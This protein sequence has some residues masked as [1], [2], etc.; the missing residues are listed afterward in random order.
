MV[1][2]LRQSLNDLFFSNNDNKNKIDDIQNDIIQLDL[3]QITPNPFQP[4]LEFDNEKIVELSQTLK[5]HGI[6]QPIVVRKGKNNHYEIIAGERRWRAAKHIG[7][8]TIPAIVKNMTDTET[9]SVALI[10]NIQR[11]SLSVIEEAKA[12][13][14][15]IS[16]HSLTQEA[17]AQRLGKSQSTIANRLRLLTLPKAIQTQI[18]NKTITE[19]HARGLMRLKTEKEQLDFLD[20]ILK[21]KLNVRETDDLVKSYL[22][23]NNTDRKINSKKN[24]QYVNKDIRIVT[25]TIKRSITLIENTGIKVDTEE[26]DFEDYYQ[27]TI[28]V[29]K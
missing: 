29:I 21:R 16:I 14:Q 28:K 26:Q 7:W 1:I 5:T 25:N 18:V 23:G 17:L 2:I 12:Y 4:R 24:I 3:A 9:A 27:I 6:I 20:K 13:E 10:E 8:T 15:L 11:E 22:E 19:R